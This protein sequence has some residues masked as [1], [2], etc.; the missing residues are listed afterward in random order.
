S[1]HIAGEEHISLRGIVEH[2]ESTTQGSLV[3][4]E[5]VVCETEPRVEIVPVGIGLERIR[6]QRICSAVRRAHKIMKN[7]VHLIRIGLEF[8]AEADIQS[9]LAGN[10]PVV[11]DIRLQA[12]VAEIAISIV[13]PVHRSSKQGRCSSE[14]SDQAGKSVVSVPVGVTVGIDL[15]AADM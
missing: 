12:D 9:Q 6:H 5:N 4:A 7:V 13:L 15:M 10:L 2:A 8:I 1:S 11:R 14:K 3:V